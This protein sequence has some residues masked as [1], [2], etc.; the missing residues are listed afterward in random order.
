MLETSP[1]MTGLQGEPRLT[2]A[3]LQSGDGCCAALA[4]YS[5]CVA[6]ANLLE[7]SLS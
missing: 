1:S 7:A 6:R 2:T 4:W 5:C 3:A